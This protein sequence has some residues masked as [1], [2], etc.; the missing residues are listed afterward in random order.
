VIRSL[1]FAVALALPAAGAAAPDEDALRRLEADA[2]APLRVIRSPRTGL[3]AFVRRQDGGALAPAGATPAETARSFVE[4]H[5]AL[6]A[7]DEVRETE[8]AAAVPDEVGTAHVR[9]QQL[10]RGVPVTGGELRVHLRGGA[11]EAVTAKTRAVPA[12]LDV[13][14]K[15]APDAAVESARRALAERLAT[16]DAVSFSA[17]RLEVLDE[18]IFDGREHGARL[19]WFVEATRLDLRQF[20]W[21]DAGSGE[22]ALSF[23]Q[24]PHA[25]NRRIH[26]SGNGPGLPGTLIRSEGG[27]PTGD[28]DADLAY[29]YSGHAHSYFLTQHGRDSFDGVGGAIVSSVHYCP[30][31]GPCPYPNAF[32]NGQQLVYGNGYASADDVDAHEFAH[33]VTDYTARLFYYMQS[34]ALN[35]SF[36]DIFGETVDLTNGQG[37]DNP[38]VRWQLGEEIPGGAARN[39]M[40]PTVF[41]DPGKMTDPQFVCQDPG[42]DAGGVHSN[43][44]VPNHAYALMVDGGSYNGFTVAAIGAAKAGRI[45][46]RALTTYL[47]SASD[48]QDAYFAV[49]Q[50]CADLVG[51]GG[52]T[53]GD[54]N[55]VK[56]ALDAVQMWMPWPCAPSQPAPPPLC[57]AGQT[58]STVFFDDFESGF[59]NWAGATGAGTNLW[60]ASD[61]FATSGRW[62][63]FG[64]DDGD[65]TPDDSRVQMTS[66]VALPAAARLQFNHAWGFENLSASHYDGGVVEY[67]T[68]G[69]GTWLDA[70]TL[71][72]GGAG[73]GG[74]VFVGRANPLAG[75]AAFVRDSYGYTATQLNLGTLAGQSVRFRFRLGTDIGGGDYGWFVDDVRIYSC[76]GGGPPTVSIGDATVTEGQSGTLNAQFAVSLSFVTTQP[77]TVTVATANGTATAGSD[78]T[79][80]SGPLTIPAG[81]ASSVVNVPVLGDLVD[82]PN[83][84][85]TV[86]LSAPVNAT[87]ADAQGLG[88]I[89]DDDATPVLSVPDVAAAE[90]AGTMTY[91]VALTNPRS[92]PITVSFATAAGTATPGVDYT[93]VSGTLTIP[94]GASSAPLPV[95][96][97]D[98]PMDEP[99]ETVVV[100]LSAPVNAT[101]GDGQAVGIIVDDDPTPTLSVADTAVGEAGGTLTFTVSLSNPRSV[102]ITVSY[103]AAPGTATAGADYTPASGSLTFPSGTTSQT[104]TVAV[105][106][107]A[108]DEFD[109]T[110]LLNLSAPV[111]AGLADPQAV[112]WIADDDP[113]PSLS[114]GDATIDEGDTGVSTTQVTVSLSAPS[115]R[116]VTV[117]YG[118]VDLT[119]RVG[120]DYVLA[121]EALTFPPGT[122]SLIREVAAFGDWRNEGDETF[123]VDLSGPTHATVA[124]GRGVVTILDDDAPGFS[125]EDVVVREGR[126]APASAVFEV[127]LSPALPDPVT[128]DYQTVV[129]TAGAAD[130]T[131]A[132]GTL[133]FGPGAFGTVEV[134]LVND[135]L[136]EGAETFTLVLSNPVGTA[137]ARDTGTATIL[138]PPGGEDFNGDGE[139]DILWR[140]DV[141]G[142]NVLWYMNGTI[143]T[144][145]TFTT[146]AALPDVRWKMV[147]TSDFDTD[148]DPDIL[149]RHDFSGEN[150]LWFMNG[151]VLQSGTFTNPS[152]LTDVRWKM[153]GTGDFN[154]DGRPDILWRH[155]FAGENVIWFMNGPALQ[156]GTFTR[157]RALVDPSWSMAGTGDFNRDGW[158]D[159]VWH[160]GISGQ[161]VIWH[162]KGENL[163][164]GAFT[165]PPSLPDTG[166]RLSAVGDFNRDDRPDL[167]W[168]HSTS[169]QI[170]VWFMEGLNLAGGTL[171]TPPALA[172][173]NWKLVGPR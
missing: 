110:V 28:A 113:L 138:D 82:E 133:T 101:L 72:S 173:V 6:F 11:V 19:A 3:P 139:T 164:G 65:T 91:T 75:R 58:A 18:G 170:A 97:L 67:S 124:D 132:S 8:A 131:A 149:W 157:P 96:L 12:A 29:T 93:Q 52:I 20:L 148:G 98:D 111:G 45:Q 44:G 53:G 122:T 147:G 92:I 86:N 40:V 9:F 64:N 142:Q 69:G 118:T 48:F 81:A 134:P 162:L 137:I 158:P 135:T 102:P 129:G 60:F 34:G 26:N 159:A 22:L 143:L 136:P 73:Y 95:P 167:V 55:Q 104:A 59:G 117:A 144:T 78:Y 100:T 51:T 168:R 13:L 23:S 50:A 121:G 105:L 39:M 25:L 169:G 130:F 4:R 17:P 127:T 5:R 37:N 128:V 32:W 16:M 41:G 71:A 89:V 108:L 27:P 1:M 88:T 103:A 36:S 116:P 146:P 99:D 172:D 140:H 49:Q 46:Y 156:S 62:H 163:L 145:G 125:V 56:N 76:V 126:H 154:A 57:P 84:T 21:I 160:H 85:F 30:S 151:S 109:E 35:E 94:A 15:V 42:V 70:G 87:L 33:G 152:A 7:V 63:L 120:E 155:T 61:V 68:D 77:V 38:G 90:A 10:H 115:G 43:S 107:D 161:I 54:C 153:V 2:G 119:A 74:H 47:L 171:T 14:P 114:V 112:G 83:E 31:G 166:W 106:D 123:A 165:N 79:A 80:V 141:S 150:V 24:L 66:S